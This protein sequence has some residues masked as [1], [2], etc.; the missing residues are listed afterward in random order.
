MIQKYDGKKRQMSIY[1]G[2]DLHTKILQRANQ[3]GK[4][5]T[6]Y[7]RQILEKHIAQEEKKE[8]DHSK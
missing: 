6:T 1:V 5:R 7:V 4:E 2:E 8:S 3:A